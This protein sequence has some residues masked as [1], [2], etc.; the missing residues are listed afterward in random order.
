MNERQAILHEVSKLSD[1][2]CEP[3]LYNNITNN[4]LCKFYCK[5]GLKL[6]EYGAE[7]I[8]VDKIT[9][10]AATQKELTQMSINTLRTSR[11]KEYAKHREAMPRM[12]AMREMS[13]SWTKLKHY[14]YVNNERLGLGISINS[15]V[16]DRKSRKEKAFEMLDNGMKPKDV[17]AK[18][19]I[20]VH[21]IYNYRTQRRKEGNVQKT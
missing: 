1:E 4:N 8:G 16:N 5:V 14:E 13:L 10:E 6:Q 18:L 15:D 3:C 20:T 19:R 2:H 17:A 21:S 12:D 9:P 11:F 7:L